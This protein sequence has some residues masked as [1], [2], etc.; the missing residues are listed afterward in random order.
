MRKAKEPRCLVGAI[1]YC[2]HSDFGLVAA[3]IAQRKSLRPCA[4]EADWKE[5]IIQGGQLP[6]G[7]KEPAGRHFPLMGY[8]FFSKGPSLSNTAEA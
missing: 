7:L 3:R 6:L 4:V 5:P 1:I 8:R 2:R